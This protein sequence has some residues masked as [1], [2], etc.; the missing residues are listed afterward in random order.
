MEH[1]MGLFCVNFH[2]RT[3]DN[4]ALS[5]ALKRRRITRYRIVPLTSVLRQKF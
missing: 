1:S 5:E 4:R 2:F 3:T